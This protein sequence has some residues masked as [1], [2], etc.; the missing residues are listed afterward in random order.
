MEKLSRAL[1]E[2]KQKTDTKPKHIFYEFQDYAYRLANDLDD[3][4]HKSL[5]FRLVKFEKREILQKARDFAIDYPISNKKDSSRAKIF[6]W[7]MKQLKEYGRIPSSTI[8]NLK[9]QISNPNIKS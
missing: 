5:Y 1:I 3:L 7:A 9:T 2:K 4:R 8:S 6:M